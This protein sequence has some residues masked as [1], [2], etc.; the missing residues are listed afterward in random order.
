MATDDVI[1]DILP[2]W[3]QDWCA[4]D[5]YSME[6][7][8]TQ[9]KEEAKLRV[10]QLAGKGRKEATTAKTQEVWDVAET[11]IEQKRVAVAGAQ[12]AKKKA[13]EGQ[14][15]PSLEQEK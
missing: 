11:T 3:L 2:T 7:S 12:K 13:H 4:P 14:K 6:E 10:A 5:I 9:K 8:A 1:F 15:S